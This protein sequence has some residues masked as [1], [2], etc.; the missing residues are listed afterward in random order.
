M[1]IAAVS[2]VFA[3]FE[4]ASVVG[5]IRDASGAV[6]QDAKVTLANT[7]TGVADGQSTADGTYEFVTVKSSIYIGASNPVR[8]LGQRRYSGAHARDL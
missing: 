8:A 5:T 6:I 7:A 1:S 2:T 4:T 3:Q